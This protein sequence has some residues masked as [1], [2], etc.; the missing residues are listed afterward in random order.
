MLYALIDLTDDVAQEVGKPLYTISI[1]I[2][3][4]NLY[5]FAKALERGESQEQDL[6][7]YLT[8]NAKSL[9]F[10]KRKPP[11]RKLSPLLGLIS[12]SGS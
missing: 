2:V 9:G 6:V 12:S 11:T 7:T 10:L 3:Y 4:L 5:F 8:Q 1:E